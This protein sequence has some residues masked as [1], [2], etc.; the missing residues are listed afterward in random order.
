MAL[1]PE[2]KF[3]KLKE[4]KFE[5]YVEHAVKSYGLTDMPKIIFLDGRIPACPNANACIEIASKTIYVSR[6]YLKRA[7]DDEI[8]DTAFHEVTHLF[9][10]SH[11]T[12]FYNKLSDAITGTWQPPSGVTVIDGGRR[13]KKPQTKRKTDIDKERCNY[14]LCRKKTK[15]I[16]CEYCRKYFCEKHIAPSPPRLARFKDPKYI[17]SGKNEY[18]YHPCTDYLHYS[19]IKEKEK[20]RRYS[21]SLSRMSWK[22]SSINIE[23]NERKR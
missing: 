22:F 1:K 15:L 13:V 17:P 11:N 12:A 2:D 3:L 14:H 10:T 8:K 20:K 18:N 16:Q 6:E 9:N 23:K 19:I 21:E 5:S 7:D 4:I